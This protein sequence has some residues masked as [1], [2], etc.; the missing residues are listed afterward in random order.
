MS[1]TESGVVDLPA[2]HARRGGGHLLS[3]AGD[4]RFRARR[5]RPSVA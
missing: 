4:N 5:G 3:G 1:V 2:R